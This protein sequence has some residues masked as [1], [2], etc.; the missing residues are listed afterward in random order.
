MGRYVVGK[1][2]ATV[3]VTITR[4]EQSRAL[5]V[6]GEELR[7]LTPAGRSLGLQ[8]FDTVAPTVAPGEAGPPPH[9]HPWEEVY[10]VLAGTLQV[11]DGEDWRDAPAGA[12]V[13]VPPMQWHSYRNG[14]PDCRFL[15]ITGP[16][17]A[18]E[19]FESADAE[20]GTWPPDMDAAL[21]VA[22]R[23]GVEAAPGSSS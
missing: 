1:R 3:T 19:F 20:V 14:T 11:F 16:G 23:H 4:A 12:C 7:P 18:R 21:A 13:C 2:E 17:R 5:S 9:R 22:A 10:V 8:V 6:L 15:T